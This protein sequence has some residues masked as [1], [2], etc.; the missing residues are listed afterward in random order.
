M[1]NF[2]VTFDHRSLFFFSEMLRIHQMELTS[3]SS[4][5]IEVGPTP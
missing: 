3:W 2:P 1:G 5:V 4:V